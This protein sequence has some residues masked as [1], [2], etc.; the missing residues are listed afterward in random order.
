MSTKSVN[1]ILTVV[2]IVFV[3]SCSNPYSSPTSTFNRYVDSAK[4]ENQEKMM[5]CY[6][7]E[8]R[9]LLA[10]VEQKSAQYASEDKKGQSMDERFKNTEVI[11]EKEKI[12]DN[13]ATL[14][15][16]IDD[17]QQELLFIKEKGN[18]KIDMSAELSAALEIMN[19]VEGMKKG[20]KNFLNNM[21]KS[22]E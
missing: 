8:T 12:S 19:K 2:V 14:T 11:I 7:D 16:K 15:V 10:E 9:K 21:K 20:V 3:C 17:Q 22:T 1:W 13:T 4:Q 6:S 18:W 5:N